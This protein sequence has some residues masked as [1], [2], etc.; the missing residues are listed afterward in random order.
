MAEEEP[1]DEG[2]D[3]RAK[4]EAMRDHAREWERKA[5]ANQ[6]EGDELERARAEAKQAKDELERLKGEASLREARAKVS[7][8]TGVPAEFV[9]GDDEESMTKFAKA[10]ADHYKPRTAPK[11]SGAGKVP[12]TDG[13]ADELSAKRDLAR[14][15]FGNNEQE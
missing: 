5:K 7:K 11:V 14:R 9:V 2:T 10:L 15:I 3:W 1:K 6:G 8:E 12:A 13:A 4:Y